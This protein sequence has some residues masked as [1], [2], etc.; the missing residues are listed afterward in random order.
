MLSAT[1]LSYFDCAV[2][3][4]KKE[5]FI[6]RSSNIHVR[7][8]YADRVSVPEVILVCVLRTTKTV[9]YENYLLLPILRVRRARVITS[10][11]LKVS[12]ILTQPCRSH[13]GRWCCGKVPIPY[14]AETVK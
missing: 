11:V 5:S 12:Y 6:K 1:V 2:K 4:K 13:P 14:F 10:P 9:R 7:T 8:R 3:K